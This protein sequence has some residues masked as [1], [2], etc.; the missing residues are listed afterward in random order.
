MPE[1]LAT[2]ARLDEGRRLLQGMHRRQFGLPSLR[3][4]HGA[5]QRAVAPAAEIRG[6][7]Q[8]ARQAR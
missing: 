4:L 6:Q 3:Q 5:I 7:K 2:L 1:T 8:P